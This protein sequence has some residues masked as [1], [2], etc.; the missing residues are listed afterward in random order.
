[1]AWRE[2]VQEVTGDADK[3]EVPLSA[4]AARWDI[5]TTDRVNFWLANL[6]HESG[7]FKRLV[8]NMNY[9]AKRLREV[10]KSRFT[11]AEAEI[12]AHDEFRI[13][14]HV[15]GGRFG[16]GP[17]GSGDG[18]KYRARGLT[19]VTFLDNYRACGTALGLNLVLFPELLETPAHAAQSAGWFWATHGC[20]EL[21]DAGDFDGACGA[22]NRGDPKK[23]AEGLKERRGWLARI[24]RVE[25]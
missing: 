18:F 6:W 17:E 7:R 20:N 12:F 4:A 8:E 5:S 3:W 2:F 21:A 23:R 16:N 1:M 19:G 9:S 14:E 11:E 15:Y 10:F 25:A 22:V 24:E 13:A